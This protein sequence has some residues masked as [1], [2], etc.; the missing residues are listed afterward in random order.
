MQNAYGGGTSSGHLCLHVER[1]NVD[2]GEVEA[3]FSHGGLHTLFKVFWCSM[4]VM[5]ALALTSLFTHGKFVRHLREEFDDQSHG[6]GMYLMEVKCGLHPGKYTVLSQAPRWIGSP[7]KGNPV[8]QVLPRTRVKRPP[9]L[10]GT[11]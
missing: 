5:E 7:C 4:R 10:R 1:L 3:R 6:V 8:S 9:W 2:Y 11:D